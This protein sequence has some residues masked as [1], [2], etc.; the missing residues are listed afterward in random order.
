[1]STQKVLKIPQGLFLFVFIFLLVTTAKGQKTSETEHNWHSILVDKPYN[2]VYKK[3][4]RWMVPLH[5]SEVKAS[6]SHHG[7]SRTTISPERVEEMA[8]QSGKLQFRIIPF[9]NSKTKIT[10]RQRQGEL[11]PMNKLE[12]SAFIDDLEIWLV[13]E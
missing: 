7:G 10:V 8:T 9:S 6:P 11:K 13:Q 3:I 12:L 2:A 5:Y 4:Y 1:M